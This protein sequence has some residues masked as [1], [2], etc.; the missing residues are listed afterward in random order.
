LVLAGYP[1]G[2]ILGFNMKELF[3]YLFDRTAVIG[4]IG[5]FGTAI[6]HWFETYGTALV[7]MVTTGYILTKWVFFLK[8][9]LTEKK[10]K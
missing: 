6:M 4:F 9:K 8:R 1:I 7:A 3:T 5:S 2:S 10:K